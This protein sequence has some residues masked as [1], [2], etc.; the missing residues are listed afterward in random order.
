MSIVK[1]WRENLDSFF[2]TYIKGSL[3]SSS[4]I[5]KSVSFF[6]T[7]MNGMTNGLNT[8]LYEQ[9]IPHPWRTMENPYHCLCLSKR[10]KVRCH[11]L[12]KNLRMVL[13][14]LNMINNSFWFLCTLVN[15]KIKKKA[16][17]Q[18]KVLSVLLLV[19]QLFTRL[20]FAFEV[21][22]TIFTLPWLCLFIYT[23]GD[24]QSCCSKYRLGILC[25]LFLLV[26]CKLYAA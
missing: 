11:P 9:E 8:H 14:C 20:L 2:S 13:H 25:C 15:I 4:R 26:L 12:L 24:S 16:G 7:C 21:V 3:V 19:M 18:L 22:F 5:S 23:Q 1:C 10:A 17:V 6:A